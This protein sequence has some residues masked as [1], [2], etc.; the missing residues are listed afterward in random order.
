MSSRVNCSEIKKD[1]LKRHPRR[2]PTQHI[3][4]R[5]AGVA[6][7]RFAE[8]NFG[9]DADAGSHGVHMRIVNVR[10]WLRLQFGR[11]W[12]RCVGCALKRAGREFLKQI[13]QPLI[14]VKLIA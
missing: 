9:V 3:A 8:T 6:H 1:F 11:E 5:D 13:R 7:A 14:G 2:E 4:H 10:D 12:V